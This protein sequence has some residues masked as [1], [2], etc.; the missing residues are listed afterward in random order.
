MLARQHGRR[1]GGGYGVQHD[2][3]TSLPAGN[4]ACRLRVRKA[5]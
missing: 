2:F 1:Y 5:A 3:L 4:T